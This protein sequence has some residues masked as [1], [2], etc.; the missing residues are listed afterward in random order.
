MTAA[1]THGRQLRV[2]LGVD[3]QDWSNYYAEFSV[4]YESLD[5]TDPGRIPISGQ[6]EIRPGINM[7][8]SLDPLVNPTRWRV[9][10]DVYIQVRNDT[11]TAW[12]DAP[13]S[14]LKIV[15]QPQRPGLGSLILDLGCKV[16]WHNQAKLDS[17]KSGIIYGQSTNS[18]IVIQRWLEASEIA[19]ADINLVA[20]PYSI[21]RPIGKLGQNSYL[22]QAADLAYANNWHYL[23]QNSSG[24]VVATEFSMVTTSAIATVTIGQDDITYEPSSDVERPAELTK[25]AGLGYDLQ[26]SA[27]T[28]VDPP[29]DVVV[30]ANDIS[31]KA[32]GSVVA[33][34]IETSRSFSI[35]ANP[36]ITEREKVSKIE[37][38]I[39]QNPSNPTQRVDYT[40]RLITSTYEAGKIDPTD[41]RLIQRVTTLR[42]RG[43]SLDPDDAF[44]NMRDVYRKTE[45]ITY[46]G[47]SET[48]T[49]YQSLEEQAAIILDDN[50]ASPWTLQTTEDFDYTWAPYV[51]G[52]FDR[53]DREK[54]PLISIRSNVDRSEANPEALQTL[55]RRYKRTRPNKPFDTEYFDYGL[56]EAEVEYSGTAAYC[57]PGGP[58]GIQKERLYTTANGMAFNQ[59]QMQVIATKH[60]DLAIGRERGYLI[61]LAINDA[62]IQSGPLPEIDVLDIDNQTYTY[63]GDALTL[64]FTPNRATAGCIGIWI[65]GGYQNAINIAASIPQSN[66]M[67]SIGQSSLSIAAA[68]PVPDLTILIDQS[69][70]IS[71]TISTA[72][73]TVSVEA[74][75]DFSIA[76]SIPTANVTSTVLATTFS[77]AASIPMATLT[78]TI[79]E[80][81]QISAS[82]PSAQLGVSIPTGDSD[83]D[84]YIAR[85]SGTYSQA[86]LDAIDAFF[87]QLKADGIYSK[88]DAIWM[89]AMDVEAD[90]L[91]NMIGTSFTATNNGATF[92]ARQGF[93]GDG[94]TAYLDSTYTPSTDVNTY[95]SS[96]G[97]NSFAISLYIRS[98]PTQSDNDFGGRAASGQN[99]NSIRMGTSSALTTINDTTVTAGITTSSVTEHHIV[100]RTAS[101]L[102]TLYTDGAS[103]GTRSDGS[104]GLPTVSQYMLA[105][106]TGAS[107]TAPSDGQYALFSVSEG[108]DS[109]E[110]A[111]FT[112]AVID[113]L[114]AFGANV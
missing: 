50:A 48:M 17:D 36:T 29:I 4:G 6:L 99:A 101:N 85:L 52:K 33:E 30:D 90:G 113:L 41:A 97:Q 71:A 98:K 51:N 79:A 22:N 42:Q 59:A 57:P 15:S 75:T 23:H 2:L 102:L 87:V 58:T 21:N 39:F 32:F 5:E 81:I 24:Q 56:D 1:L 45:I 96:A 61:E 82:I 64:E 74:S 103:E 35:G 89:L 60:Q 88:F 10:Q 38:L 55:I 3:Q 13:W 104:N 49:R 95:A 73:L 26:Q 43:R 106:R 7:P 28:V 69:F 20:L 80:R 31:P 110:A 37:A 34:R 77:I 93:T 46:G 112:T 67:L 44:V 70:D 11:D 84:A 40:D 19:P 53:T 9:G 47:G 83:A 65:N 111:N 66:L 68:I 14:R 16:L 108:L 105:G 92:A 78:P 18:N 72:T 12:L 25:V 100:S 8:E 109:T 91:L 63:K 62:L 86:E 27:S 94:S 54:T 114:T 76:A 107:A